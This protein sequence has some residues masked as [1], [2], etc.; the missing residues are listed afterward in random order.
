M[1]IIGLIILWQA[2]FLITGG[3]IVKKLY[4]F[5]KGMKPIGTIVVSEYDGGTG[6][7][8]RFKIDDPYEIEKYNSVIFKVENSHKKITI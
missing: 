1:L 5:H 6:T 4:R 7:E 2:I 3:L 8:L